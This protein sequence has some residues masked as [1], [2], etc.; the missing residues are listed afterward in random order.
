MKSLV[1]PRATPTTDEAVCTRR[2]DQPPRRRRVCRITAAAAPRRPHQIGS[3]SGCRIQHR[4]KGEP[5]PMRSAPDQSSSHRWR[6]AAHIVL[7]AIGL[8]A[9][10]VHDVDRT[11]STTITASEHFASEAE[12]AG[13]GTD[14]PFDAWWDEFGDDALTELIDR[15]LGSNLTA[16]DFASRVL[17]ARAVARQA[18]AERLPL[19][20]ATR[21]AGIQWSN[22][23][24]VDDALEG[25][26]FAGDI[27]LIVSWEADIFGRLR[28]REQ[29]SGPL[30]RR[31]PQ[32]GRRGAA[33]GL[34]VCRSGVLPRERV[35][36]AAQAPS[37]ADRSRYHAA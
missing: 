24:D 37:A 35:A 34:W 16:S 8:S 11:P 2:S 27:G 22:E 15:A 28:S 30:C 9:C 10:T 29:A 36:L 13:Q 20:D 19:L 17:A 23:G 12:T 33:C 32:E 1:G 31:S 5:H 3:P 7:P 14:A 21:S 25:L 4:G 18:G 6:R 26:D